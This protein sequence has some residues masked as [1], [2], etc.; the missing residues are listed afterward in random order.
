MKRV[1]QR[2]FQDYNTEETRRRVL[3]LPSTSTQTD[4]TFIP[5]SFSAT[6]WNTAL[7]QLSTWIRCNLFFSIFTR[8]LLRYENKNKTGLNTSNAVNHQGK[9]LKSFPL[10]W[11]VNFLS[12][13]E[14]SIARTWDTICDQHHG[15]VFWSLYLDFPMKS[16]FPFG[17]GCNWN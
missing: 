1:Y 9:I 12:I 13:S 3:Y 16:D 14:P 11:S 5:W 6:H 2:V 17:R 15:Q 10:L 8:E 7:C 4:D